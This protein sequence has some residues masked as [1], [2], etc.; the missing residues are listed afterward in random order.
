M[1]GII[2]AGGNGSRLGPITKVVNKHLLPIY[3]KPMI[4]YPLSVLLKIGIK[5]ILIISTPE[6]V[7]S[8]KKMVGNGSSL[9][10][11]IDYTIQDTPKGIA[12][13]F[14]IGESFIG[15][16]RVCLILGDNIIYGRGVDEISKCV[17]MA[18]GAD[19]FACQVQNPTAFGVVELDNDGNV[20]SIEEK[21]QHPKSNYAM[22]GIYFYNSDVVKYAKQLTP[23]IRGEIEIG[24]INNLYLQQGKIKVHV[25]NEETIWFDAGSPQGLLNAAKFVEK[26]QRLEGTYVGC[27][28]QLAW[29]QGYIDT[30]E[31]KTIATQHN[32][33]EYYRYLLSLIEKEE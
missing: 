33:V 8:L 23:T 4:Y 31:L 12:D 5:D 25:L 13:A 7:L 11:S 19:I 2:L 15:N 30:A 21:P 16:D 17:T 27:I 26:M 18:D 10:V 20:L 6:A 14:L 1:K 9:G 32:A 29:E 28:E 24:Q 22:L 3:D